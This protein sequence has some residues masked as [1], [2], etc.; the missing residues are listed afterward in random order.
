[1]VGVISPSQ[2]KLCRHLAHQSSWTTKAVARP[3]FIPQPRKTLEGPVVY[4]AFEGADGYGKRAEAF[5][6]HHDLD[7]ARDVPFYLVPARMD[8]F[9]D[10]QALINAVRVALNGKIP[11]A[12]ALDT[13]SR[14][15]RGSESR[16]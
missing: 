12:V 13:L 11:F 14:S 9:Q 10:H 7:E 2:A 4:C 3:P 6:R 15:L 5:R 1:M 16:A 8:F